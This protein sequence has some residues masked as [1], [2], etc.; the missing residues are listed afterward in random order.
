MTA[1]RTAPVCQAD[2]T[3]GNNENDHGATSQTLTAAVIP[4]QP[5]AARSSR[6]FAASIKQLFREVKHALTASIDAVPKP[7]KRTRR[8]S[9]EVWA[10]FRMAARKIMRGVSSL[11]A[12]A[13]IALAS[14]NP[15]DPLNPYWSN[16]AVTDEK[17]TD[18]H[19]SE[20]NHLF[21]HL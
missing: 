18:I 3:K 13:F 21:P 10:G 20:Q 12:L 4:E 6:G 17:T 9:G 14:D 2:T 8:R 11:P 7:K 15:L 16:P 1:W 5:S 19:T